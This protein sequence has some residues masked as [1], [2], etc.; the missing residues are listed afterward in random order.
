MRII[1][2]GSELNFC[3]EWQT[4]CYFIFNCASVV[5]AWYEVCMNNCMNHRGHVEHF[6]FSLDHLSSGHTFSFLITDSKFKF[7]SCISVFHYMILSTVLLVG[8]RKNKLRHAVIM[9]I[10]IPASFSY[11][12]EYCVR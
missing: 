8:R 9:L 10:F 2:F 3:V 6:Y 1:G 4:P 7:R 12:I 5:F 11:Y